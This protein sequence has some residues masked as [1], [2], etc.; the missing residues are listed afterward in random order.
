MKKT[1][2]TNR[3]GIQTAAW[4]CVGLLYS[5]GIGLAQDVRYNSMPGTNFAKYHTYKMG[6]LRRQASWPD[7]RS[8]DH[9]GRRC[10]TSTEGVREEC[11]RVRRHIR[12]LPDCCGSRAAM[13]C[14][15]NG[16]LAFWRHGNGDQ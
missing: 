4:L 9:P 12:L 14:L 5:C 2:S 7:H 13:E 16:R 10:A 15:W 1:N 3:K 8:G 11:R 6:R